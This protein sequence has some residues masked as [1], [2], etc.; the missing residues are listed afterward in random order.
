MRKYGKLL[1]L[2]KIVGVYSYIYKMFCTFSYYDEFQV[3]YNQS[4][5]R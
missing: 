5:Y 2:V 3:N 4:H 1:A